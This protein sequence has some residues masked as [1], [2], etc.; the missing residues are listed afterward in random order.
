MIKVTIKID[1]DTP[2]DLHDLV[3]K[4]RILLEEEGFSVNSVEAE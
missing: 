2:S 4:I 3:E 1:E